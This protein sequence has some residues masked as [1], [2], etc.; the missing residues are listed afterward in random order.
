[1]IQQRG[2]LSE[3]GYLM[4]AEYISVVI[5]SYEKQGEEEFRAGRVKVAD[6]IPEL[7][8]RRAAAL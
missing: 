1:V 5:G 4:S 2:S 6:V 7:R 8:S 3:V